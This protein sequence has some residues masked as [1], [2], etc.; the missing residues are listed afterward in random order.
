ML[1]YISVVLQEGWD[2]LDM[3]RASYSLTEHAR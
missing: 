2:G 3:L 1:D